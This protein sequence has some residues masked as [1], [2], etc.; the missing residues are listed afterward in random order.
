MQ[1]LAS[2]YLETIT[3]PDLLPSVLHGRTEWH[4]SRGAPDPSRSTQ[5]DRHDAQLHNV[6]SVELLPPEYGERCGCDVCRDPRASRTLA[7]SPVAAAVN[8]LA[9]QTERVIPPLPMLGY[10]PEDPRRNDYATEFRSDMFLREELRWVDLRASTSKERYMGRQLN[11]SDDSSVK[12]LGHTCNGFPQLPVIRARSSFR[13]D[14]YH[15]MTY[16]TCFQYLCT[17]PPWHYHIREVINLCPRS[18]SS[19]EPVG[20]ISPEGLLSEEW[21][22]NCCTRSMGNSRPLGEVSQP[23]GQPLSGLYDRG[24]KMVPCFQTTTRKVSP[25]TDQPPQ[26][27][28]HRRLNYSRELA[29][30][31]VEGMVHTIRAQNEEVNAL[32]ADMKDMR[33][34]MARF[35]ASRKKAQQKSLA[36]IAAVKARMDERI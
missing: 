19:G 9:S 12:H 17:L 32:R 23:G 21:L 25:S 2:E 16:D 34:R 30:S 28:E 7:E 20:N 26:E 15:S 8:S 29:D 13:G 33:S 6:P 24:N 31:I 5:E 11:S 27:E 14:T 1:K 35:F 4:T 18:P 10:H 36:F 22:V 3:S